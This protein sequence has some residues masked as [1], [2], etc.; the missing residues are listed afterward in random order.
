MEQSEFGRLPGVL[1]APGR[2]FKAI[3]ERPTWIVA[4]VALVAVSLLATVVI[5]PRLDMEKIVRE[6]IA[7][8]GRQVSADIVDRQIEFA[9]KFRWVLAGIGLVAQPVVYLLVALVFWVLFRLLGSELDFKRSFSVVVHGYLPAVV[10]GLL[11][12]PVILSQ[13][14]LDYER[15]RSGS[16]LYSNPGAFLGPG[17]SKALMSLLSSLDVFSLWS[18]VLLAIGYRVVGRVSRAAAIGGVVALWAVY[19]LGK[20]GLSAIF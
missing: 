17:T 14:T 4:L 13:P 18:V 9:Q 20:V 15:V 7:Q 19:V 10:S 5:T 16:F 6:Q 2:T 1:V 8:S 3:A 12:L 11:S